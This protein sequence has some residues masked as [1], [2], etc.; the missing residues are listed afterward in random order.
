MYPSIQDIVGI[1]KYNQFIFDPIIKNGKVETSMIGKPHTYTGGYTVVFPFKV[2]NEKFAFRCWHKDLGDLKEQY[3]ITAEFISKANLPY[4][5]ETNYIDEGILVNG[6]KYPTTRMS[7]VEGDKLKDFI[8]NNKANKAVLLSFAQN[9]V[10]MCNTFHQQKI[11]HG[12][13]QHG[14][15]L[16][17]SSGQIKL[18]DYD[19]LYVPTLTNYQSQI[20]G[21]PQYQHPSRGSSKT[22]SF[23]K[24]D[25]FSELII[26]IGIIAI[27]ENPL[28]F[29]KYQID[30][31]EGLFFEAEDFA[32]ISNS[33]VF[34]ELENIKEL[35]PYLIILKKY[36]KEKEY[37]KLE[38]FIKEIEAITTPPKINSFSLD[39]YI[40]LE[41][42]EVVLSW[43]ITGAKKILLDNIG[44]ISSINSIKLK[45]KFDTIYTI[46]AENEFGSKTQANIEVKVQPLPIIKQINLPTIQIDNSVN[47]SYNKINP[48]LVTKRLIE[49]SVKTLN[50]NLPK[51]VVNEKSLF[52]IENFSKIVE[53]KI[54]NYFNQKS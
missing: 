8:K 17:E 30:K 46:T 4:F 15:I 54:L 43:E 32:D 44:D 9:F 41:G 35:K 12:D 38:P 26:Y 24:N 45:P 31:T 1:I 39:K 23:E 34:K 42:L 22:K 5:A 49:F 21:L 33:L 28:L 10:E 2:Q 36:C 50:I 52:E 27:S 25:Y 3:K 18:I 29:E 40:I 37:S 11:A 51:P 48:N 13:L 47:L 53:Q 14:N 19:S 20:A 6:I 7:W 16:I